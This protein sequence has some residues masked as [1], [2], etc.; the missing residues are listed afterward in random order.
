MDFFIR[1]VILLL[2]IAVSIPSIA[3]ANKPNSWID[4]E[5]TKQ[6]AKEVPIPPWLQEVKD[7]AENVIGEETPPDTIQYDPGA[8]VSI[9]SPTD[10]TLSWEY[11]LE[12]NNLVEGINQKGDRVFF[13]ASGEAVVGKS[14]T[15]NSF[16]D[17]RTIAYNKALLTAKS[18][19]TEFVSSEI[20]SERALSVFSE[21]GETP[22]SIRE[23]ITRP[24]SIL[25]KL[26]TLTNLALDYEIRKFDP[27]WD[28]RNKTRETKVQKLIGSV[29]S[30]REDISSKAR[31]FLQGAT[32][33][34]NAEGLVDNQYVIKVGIVWST[35]SAQIAESIY[36]PDVEAPIGKNKRTI[37]EQLNSLTNN[38]LA[39]TLGVR[40]WWDQEGLPVIL[41]FASTHGG[42]S[43]IIA[44]KKTSLRARA[45]IA[46]FV[47]EQIV[48]SGS[49][50]S[51]E[52]MHYYEDDSH[53]AFNE[54]EFEQTIRAK[55]KTI[56]LIGVGTIKYKKIIHPITKKRIAV[57]V[58]YWSPKTSKKASDFKKTSKNLKSKMK[59][60]RNNTLFE[61][62]P[63]QGRNTPNNNTPAPGF[64]GIG[65][66]ADDF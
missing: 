49:L 11:Y 1:S 61:N 12:K 38:E 54:Q 63:N 34:F 65:S 28:G 64:Q 42:G 2:S 57:N 14:I 25:E 39:A 27:E 36:N 18:E 52:T 7:I 9:A 58:M 47:A 53:V 31:L 19:L 30:Y 46:Q 5:R 41:S 3:E 40:I 51:G 17:S 16:A 59:K 62:Y 26:H 15:S 13:I 43:P 56:K 48:S 6:K 29:E 21:G 35:R 33:M 45:Q 23:K 37:R 4:Q 44:K 20:N 50:G 60:V 8:Q 32:P 55:S 66:S 24:L 22:D 10:P